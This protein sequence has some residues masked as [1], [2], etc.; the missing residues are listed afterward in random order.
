MVDNF[1]T[2]VL[3]KLGLGY[4]VI[5]KLNPR[6]VMVSCGAFGRS[7]PMKHSRGLHSAAEPVWQWCCR[8]DRLSRW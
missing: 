7:G 1:S 4:D 5:S 3:E 6:I 8:C 2:G